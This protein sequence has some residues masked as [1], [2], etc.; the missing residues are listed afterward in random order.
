MTIT[1]WLLCLLGIVAIAASTR[2]CVSLDQRVTYFSY[3]QQQQ[4]L[5]DATR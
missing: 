1:N 5:E 4:P 3:S 2:A